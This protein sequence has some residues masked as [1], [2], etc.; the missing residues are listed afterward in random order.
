MF[1]RFYKDYLFISAIGI[2][3]KGHIGAPLISTFIE[4]MF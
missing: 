4:E 2:L 1:Y 3:V